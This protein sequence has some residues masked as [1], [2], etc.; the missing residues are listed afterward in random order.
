MNRHRISLITA[1]MTAGLAGCAQTQYKIE[2]APQSKN[3]QAQTI[4]ST[5]CYQT[6]KINVLST[7]LFC[8]IGA[9]ICRSIRDSRYEECMQSRG[10]KVKAT[11]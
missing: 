6:S 5:Q 3:T 9:P 1:L 10:Y 7:V 4:D 11:D 2:M 8:G